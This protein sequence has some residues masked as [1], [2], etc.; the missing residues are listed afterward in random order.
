MASLRAAAFFAAIAFAM[1]S[2]AES[3]VSWRGYIAEAS[4][5]FGVPAGWIEQVMRAE[6][7]GQTMLDGR[8]IRSRAGAI[9]LMQL[10]PGTWE[11]LR[12]SLALGSNPDDPHDNILAGTL[13]LRMMYERFGYPG[14][15]AAYDAGPNRFAAHLVTGRALPDET[16]AY[17][18]RVAV[19]PHFGTPP[20]FK[21]AGDTLFVAPVR[22]EAQRFLVVSTPTA[23]TLFAVRN[24]Q[25]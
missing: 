6:S 12:R 14:M 25:P 21:P 2:H 10:M 7:N 3:V 4:L 11:M 1:P 9:G 17:L 13:Y 19:A 15:F 23:T 20:E 8:P 22:A 5:R 18:R 24:D 16:I